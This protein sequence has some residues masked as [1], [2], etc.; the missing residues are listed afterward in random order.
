MSGKNLETG[1]QETSQKTLKT[2]SRWREEHPKATFEP[3]SHRTGT[4][5]TGVVLE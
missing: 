2:I 4:G 1:W 3:F 5:Q